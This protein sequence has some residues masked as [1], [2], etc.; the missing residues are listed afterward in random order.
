MINDQEYLPAIYGSKE[1]PIEDPVEHRMC[2]QTTLDW[3]GR[4]WL[5]VEHVHRRLSEAVLSIHHQ[6]SS[7]SLALPK[8]LSSVVR[9]TSQKGTGEGT[10]RPP[11]AVSAKL[12]TVQDLPLH[13]I[14]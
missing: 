11:V 13:P 3:E 14:K 1:R 2:L 10:P 4:V 9:Y 6:Q 7:R 5:L 8:W 12:V